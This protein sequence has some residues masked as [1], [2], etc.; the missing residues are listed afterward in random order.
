MAVDSHL[1][2]QVQGH[3]VH[4]HQV[5]KALFR[6]ANLINENWIVADDGPASRLPILHNRTA[7]VGIGTHRPLSA[8]PVLFHFSC[9]YK[10]PSLDEEKA[11]LVWSVPN[12]ILVK[13]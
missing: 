7:R 4:D 6:P 12:Q 1:D 2:H 10:R 8:Q 3:P 9:M 11:F 5:P 13:N